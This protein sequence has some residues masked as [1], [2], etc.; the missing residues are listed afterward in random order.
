VLPRL[1]VLDLLA[2]IGTPDPDDPF[3]APIGTPDPVVLGAV[4]GFDEVGSLLTPLEVGNLLTEPAAGLVAAA[5][6]LAAVPVAGLFT[7]AVEAFGAGAGKALGC[8]FGGAAYIGRLKVFFPP[9]LLSARP[10]GLLAVP[11]LGTAAPV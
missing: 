4:D 11:T 2:P 10:R 8:G 1:T 3:L 9:V 6:D 5:A 7:T